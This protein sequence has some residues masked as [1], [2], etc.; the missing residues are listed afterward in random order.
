MPNIWKNIIGKRYGQLVVLKYL[1]KQN[2]TR[3]RV[4]ARC[5]CGNVKDYFLNNLQRKGHTQSCGCLRTK[6]SV[7]RF[8]THGLRRH[9]LYRTWADIK[10][11]CYNKNAI[12]YKRYGGRGAMMCE[13]WRLNPD[14]FIVWAVAKG[15][16]KGLKIDKDIKVPGNLTYGPEF[17]SIVTNKVNTQHT[18]RTR[19]LEYKGTIQCAAQWADS[20]GIERSKFHQRVKKCGYNLAEYFKLWG[21]SV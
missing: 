17:C 10:T 11:R 8:V 12:R 5:D 19:Q 3:T 4:K 21:F 13:D 1:G 16:K 15:W 2:Y 20:I 6:E 9:P 14:H 18:S 7:V